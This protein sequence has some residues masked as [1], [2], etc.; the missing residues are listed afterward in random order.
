MTTTAAATPLTSG[1][2]TLVETG[3][4]GVA[5]RALCR[6]VLTLMA[7]L[8]FWSVAPVLIGW[9]PSVVLT[10]SM[11]PAVAPGDVLVYHSVAAEELRKDQVLVV[12]DPDHEGR[13]RSHRL[14]MIHP[15]G[16]L[17][18]RGDA[19]REDDSSPVTFADVRGVA[20][21]R[22]PLVG[23]PVVWA[24][25][26]RLAPLGALVVVVGFSLATVARRP[27]PVTVRGVW[28]RR[29]RTAVATAAVTAVL[30]AG[31]A[32]EADA[33]FVAAI[34]NRTNSLA[35]ATTF[36][37]YRD[38]VLADAPAL[39]WRVAEASGTTATDSSGSSRPGT[40]Y[41]STLGQ[42]SPVVSEPKDRAITVA[43][44]TRGMVTGTTSYA[45]PTTGFSVEAWFK[46]TSTAGG[47]I[48]GM[49]GSSG[50]TIANNAT[51]DRQLYL[52]PAGAVVFGV[53]S[54]TRA[55]L[56][57]T[58]GAY[59]NGAWHHVVGTYDG[60]TMRLYVDGAPAGSRTGGV[61][62]LTSGFWRAGAENLSAW[63]TPPTSSYFTGSLDELAVYPTAL[64]A[65]RVSA[66][67]SA[68]VSG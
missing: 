10:G 17:T 64:S 3:W 68:A 49:G 21:L 18:L 30:T 22:V 20:S 63:P 67:Y 61:P 42:E 39:Y 34:D 11:E 4:A 37:P 32:G 59:N 28:R 15:D 46:T 23:R 36:Y 62:T 2:S 6:A 57:S 16:T 55:T 7:S 33:A 65:A 14:V 5:A 24:S 40:Y 1:T 27:R 48:F 51:S 31:V 26:R 41:S 53:G 44:T 35:A 25:E 43:A 47:R 13:L 52:S 56:A 60:V 9:H 66:H 12:D 50:S 54:S 38:A 8:V 58:G 45:P 29:R 19:N